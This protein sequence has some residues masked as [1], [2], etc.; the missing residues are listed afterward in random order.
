MAKTKQKKI[1]SIKKLHNPYKKHGLCYKC[2]KPFKTGIMITRIFYIG[3]VRQ[4]LK[5]HKLC[6]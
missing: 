6:F 5:Y 2:K 3:G 4:K 1:G